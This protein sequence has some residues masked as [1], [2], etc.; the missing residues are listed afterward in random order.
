MDRDYAALLHPIID[1]LIEK[2]DSVMFCD[3]P[4]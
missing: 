3:L 4:G 1:P 2:P